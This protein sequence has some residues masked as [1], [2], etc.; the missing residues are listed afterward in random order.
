MST[1]AS[2][3]RSDKRVHEM[4][5][6]IQPSEQFVLDL[7]MQRERDFRAVRPDLGELRQSHHVQISPRG[8]KRHLIGRLAF[9]RQQDRPSFK[10][11]RSAKTK[12]NRLR[13]C[14][15]GF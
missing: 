2:K 1:N 5:S 15:G 12:I 4:K 14:N 9:N 8:L 6:A 11:Q 3:L 7:V 13:R 10:A